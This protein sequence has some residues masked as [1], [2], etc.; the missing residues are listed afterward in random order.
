M[1]RRATIGVDKEEEE[2]H[3]SWSACDL[4]I[5]LLHGLSVG[6]LSAEKA[7]SRNIT[8]TRTITSWAQAIGLQVQLSACAT[9]ASTSVR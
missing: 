8:C 7:I 6:R 9:D 1:R 4:Y 5:Q 2:R 3:V